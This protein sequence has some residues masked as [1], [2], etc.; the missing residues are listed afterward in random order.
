MQKDK[1]NTFETFEGSWLVEGAIS[2]GSNNQEWRITW[3]W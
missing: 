3:V 1:D 2:Y